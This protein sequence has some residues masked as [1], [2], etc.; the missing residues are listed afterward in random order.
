MKQI[1][2]T[3][4]KIKKLK[5][6]GARN[7]AYSA[8]DAFGKYAKTINPKSKKE[9]FE[10]LKKA[11]KILF[12]SRP[13]E[14]MMRNTLR[15]AMY[16]SNVNEIENVGDIKK[17]LLIYISDIKK[18]LEESK[19]KVAEIGEKRIPKNAT[20]F[21]H[22]H[23]STV[24]AI[25]KKCKSKNIKVFCTETRPLYQ[26]RTTA[27]E[28]VKAGIETTMIVDSSSKDI[29]KKCDMV[30]IG[31]DAIGLDGVYNK[32]GSGVIS[33]FAEIYDVPLYVAAES[34]KFDPETVKGKM[35]VVEQR[36][37]KEVWDNAPK[38]LKILN[39]AFE[40]VEKD[41]INGI[42][43]EDGIFTTDVIHDMFRK[44]HPWMF[45]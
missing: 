37:P 5:I 10:E 23:S 13:T 44:N 27:K 6:Q 20:I 1:I 45:E 32:I 16:M 34:W 19:E 11:K 31:A 41:E 4:E 42:I 35:T 3:A 40:F 33:H 24:T 43:T 22:C 28:L 29:I 14:P 12:E 26:G 38:N 17:M 2:E 15:Y 30:L 9:F 21:T 25:L 18:E 36:D 8:L 7:V 39:P